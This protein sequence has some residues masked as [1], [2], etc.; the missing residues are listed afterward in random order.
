MKRILCFLLLFSTYFS[1]TCLPNFENQKLIDELTQTGIYYYWNGGDLKKVENGKASYKVGL[2][3]EWYTGS[4]RGNP[5]DFLLSS[6][7][8]PLF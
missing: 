3:Q 1:N 6:T 8:R 7:F 4:L 2:F 5:T